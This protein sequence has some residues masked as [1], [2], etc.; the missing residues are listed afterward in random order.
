MYGI[1]VSPDNLAA[2][3]EAISQSDIWYEKSGVFDTDTF[4]QYCRAAAQVS[5][6]VLIVDAE[7][8]DDASLIKGIRQFRLQRGSTR[9]LLLA[10]GRQPG[11]PTISTLLKF[12]VFDVVAPSLNESD[13]E[14]EDGLEQDEELNTKNL[15]ESIR[16]QLELEPGYANAARWDL[17]GD[18]KALDKPKSHEDHKSKKPNHEKS[19]GIDHSIIE[20][21]QD[22]DIAPP[23]IRERQTLVET[24][25][26][27][28]V[29]AVVGVE[30]AVGTTHTTLLITNFISRKGLKVAVVEANESRDF[31]RIEAA[32]EGMIGYET[33]HSMF[34]IGGVDYYKYPYKYDIAELL[35]QKYDYI[36]LDLGDY[37]SSPYLEEFYRAH[38][39]VI[40]GHG[41]EWR[42]HKIIEFSNKHSHRDQSQWIYCIP[43]VEKVVIDDVH[44]AIVEGKLIAIPSHPDPYQQLKWTD[45][46]LENMLREY[47]GKKRNPNKQIIIYSI[48]LAIILILAIM[49]L[50][51]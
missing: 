17:D 14:D 50:I 20:E 33:S 24:I 18:E 47:L 42:Q 23:P 5:L 11:D 13:P 21:L 19:L 22:I 35:E 1:I 16:K 6:K 30:A 48:L 44:K 8:S 28:V 34:S 9:V 26:G 31:G 49:L 38:V 41:S 27:T 40:V 36:L 15:A 2:V 45:V 4:V 3:K 10:P 25:I 12:Q 32:Y 37:Q 43:H 29:I 7:S 46:I 51:K 39:Q